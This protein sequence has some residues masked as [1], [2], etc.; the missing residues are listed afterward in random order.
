MTLLTK[1]HRSNIKASSPVYFYFFS[2]F[3]D[4]PNLSFLVKTFHPTL[5]PAKYPIPS[6][7]FGPV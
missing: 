1:S 4:E 7:A 6:K 2:A 5:P 3:R